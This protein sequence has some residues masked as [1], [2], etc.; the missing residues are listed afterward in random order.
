MKQQKILFFDTETTARSPFEARPVQIAWMVFDQ[1]GN[2][3]SEHDHI[4]KPFGFTIPIETTAIHGI[5]TKMAQKQGEDFET[6]M[7]LFVKDWNEAA[8]TV[9]HNYNYDFTVLNCEIERQGYGDGLN[10]DAPMR[11]TMQRT[12]N[13]C[14]IPGYY[15]KY[16]WPRL[17][18]LHQYLFNCDFEGAHNALFDVKATAKCFFELVNRGVRGFEKAKK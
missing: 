17:E 6:V 14:R 10:G 11:C 2:V 12:T 4:I 8:L 15:G 3:L 7:D 1:K 13:L 9:A 5:T 16:K 18:E